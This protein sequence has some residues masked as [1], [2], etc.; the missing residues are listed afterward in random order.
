MSLTNASK[1]KLRINERVVWFSDTGPEYGTIR[2]IG[3]LDDTGSEWMAGVD[4]DNPVGSGT[5]L[6]KE[7][8]LF[9]AALNHASLVPIIGLIKAS[10]LD[11]PSKTI[12][13]RKSP[14]NLIDCD[15]DLDIY[16]RN[17]QRQEIN[18]SKSNYSNNF[19]ENQKMDTC[20]ISQSSVNKTKPTSRVYNIPIKLEDDTFVTSTNEL[21]QSQRLHNQK[22]ISSPYRKMKQDPKFQQE[23]NDISSITRRL[24]N[25]KL[26]NKSTSKLDTNTLPSPSLVMSNTEKNPSA[27]EFIGKSKG[28]QGNNNSCYLDA[29]LFAMFSATTLFDSM[30]YRPANKNDISGYNEIQRILREDI[31]RPL[32]NRHFVSAE[33]VM[34]FRTMLEKSSTVA[35][36]TDE[37]KDPEEFL[38]LL[39]GQI[40]KAEPYLKL[41]TGL[42]SYL[43]QL[44]VD[45]DESIIL[46]SVQD[47]FEQSFSNSNI[48]LREIPPCLLIQMPRFG[49]QYKMYSRIKPSLKLDITDVLECVPRSCGHK[50]K[51]CEMIA[52]YECPACYKEKTGRTS[53]RLSSVT[54]CRNCFRTKHFS[55]SHL[56]GIE[57]HDSTK[58]KLDKIPDEAIARYTSSSRSSSKIKEIPR[59]QMDLFAVLCIETSHYVCFVKCGPGPDAA[60]CFFDSMADRKGK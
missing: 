19:Y 51:D 9:N 20:P 24:E 4:F 22:K 58:T 50:G 16:N 25:S 6:Y 45:K 57:S 23:I 30:L 21:N 2:W 47:L 26:S 29:T 35:G 32:R 46:P 15:T 39:L 33:Q 60:W 31:V 3:K 27:R 8:Q 40:L 28:I 17:P 48:R 43:Y 55:K 7:E 36:L 34:N 11:E 18:Q 1:P 10:D 12:S 38:S 42:E 14:I 52:T 59:I 37:E 56:T 41:S 13:K 49:R 44:I 53:M 5:G 54:F